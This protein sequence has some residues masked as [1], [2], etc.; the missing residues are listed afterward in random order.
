VTSVRPLIAIALIATGVCPNAF[1]DE[2]QKLLSRE[3][4]QALL[5]DA[6]IAT[7]EELLD[8][9]PGAH[10]DITYGDKSFISWSD[11]ENGQL[12]SVLFRSGIGWPPWRASGAGNWR[13]SDDGRYC[14]KV[15]YKW[16]SWPTMV[17]WCRFFVR[18]PD[19]TWILKS[20][21]GYPDWTVRLTTKGNHEKAD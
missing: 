15:G 19:G 3:E 5:P 21:A 10:L 13:I 1:G 7:R 12:E 4:V 20:V 18:M 8:L 17:E 11:G 2:P 6:H 14:G 9:M 16:Y